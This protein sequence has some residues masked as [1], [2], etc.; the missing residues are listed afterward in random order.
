MRHQNT[1]LATVSPIGASG[2]GDGAQIIASDI[3]RINA[4]APR[5]ELVSVLLFQ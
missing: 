4:I 1:V 2:V 5:Y 3:A